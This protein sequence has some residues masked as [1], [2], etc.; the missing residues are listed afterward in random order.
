MSTSR[1][2]M[3]MKAYRQAASNVADM[4]MDKSALFEKYKLRIYHIA[5]RI[6]E[7][8]PDGSP[9]DFEDLVSYGAIGLFE[10]VDRFDPERN[11]QFSTFADYR[12]RGAMFD[13]L[14]S[15]DTMS[16]HS[17]DQAKEVREK[18]ELLSQQFG[19]EPTNGEVA[20]ALEISLDDYHALLHK[21]RTV[22]HVPIETDAE[23]TDEP[24][25][26]LNIL[27]DESNVSAVDVLLD[28]EFRAQ[29][30]G[31]I[32]QL[33]DRKRQCVLL[34]YGRNLNLSEIAAVFDVT[35]SRISQILN[36]VRG[37]LRN[38]LKDIASEYGYGEKNE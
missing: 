36:S 23:S 3:G 4:E 10:A 35:P 28:E 27:A 7:K 29:I 30:R 31:A 38:A 6:K 16:R 15:L 11:N 25:S 33:S 13:A 26:L 1:L 8:V 21:T 34:Y 14:R 18:I 9:I 5:H 17:R 20:Q 37:E 12:I 32:E 2:K 22:S 19:R 24:R